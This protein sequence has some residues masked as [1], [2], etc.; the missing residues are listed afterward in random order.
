MVWAIYPKTHLANGHW[1]LSLLNMKSQKSLKFSH[2]PSK[3][4]T[5]GPF[6]IA[7]IRKGFSPR[8]EVCPYYKD[9]GCFIRAV[10]HDMVVDSPISTGKLKIIFPRIHKLGSS[11]RCRVE[12]RKKQI[13]LLR[14]IPTMTCWVEV[15]R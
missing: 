2:W 3:K 5:S 12:N 1:T 10:R 11:H 6:Y 15:V 7:H 14:V 9:L 4:T 8:C 13:T